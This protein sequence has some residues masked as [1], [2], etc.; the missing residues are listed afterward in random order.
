[1]GKQRVTVS[2]DEDVVTYLETVPNRSAVVTEAVRLYR[3]RQLERELEMAYRAG[4][5][6]SLEIASE[7]E[8]ADAAVD[9]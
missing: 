5:K 7:W 9:E 1:M 8:A 4:R 6:E 3:E 2:L